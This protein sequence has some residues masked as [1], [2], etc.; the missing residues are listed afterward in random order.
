MPI[1]RS[2][3][4]L[5]NIYGIIIAIYKLKEIKEGIF[6]SED[7]KIQY[8]HLSNGE[9]YA[10]REAGKGD[11]ILL[12]V[13]GN[14][15][16]SKHWDMVMDNL[17]NKYK[18]YAVDLRGFGFSSY[19]KEINSLKDFSEDLKLF[20]DA[21]NIKGFYAAGW[22][23]GGG[24]VMQFAA[25]YNDYVK[26]IILVESV[27]VKGYPMF[28]KDEKGQPILGQFLKN[29]QEI[30]EDAIQVAPV[31]QALKNRDKEFYRGLWNMVIYTQKQPSPDK[32]E[33]YLEDML[34]QRN[35]VDVDYALLTFNITDEF[36]GVTKGTG[37]VRHIKCPVLILQGEKDYVVPPYMGEEI[38]KY[39]PHGDYVV[40][41]D[42]GHSPLVDC[43][44]VLVDKIV[45]FIDK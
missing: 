6:M 17:Q 5:W 41:K 39:I 22:S 33:E 29:K 4:I 25:D 12:L 43:L 1:Y 21:I 32:Y 24:V 26:K 45:R 9:T 14:M 31:L 8:V 34:T 13:H 3:L 35:L 30:S 23:T 37:D 20:V 28:K 16:S 44:E 27:G 18:I 7:F 42:S 2:I 38:A 15:S 10:Y 19:N 36:N 40:L 11:E